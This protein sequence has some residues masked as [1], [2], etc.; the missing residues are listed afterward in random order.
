MTHNVILRSTINAA[1]NWLSYSPNACPFKHIHPST[2]IAIG[3]VGSSRR[4]TSPPS[5][6]LVATLANPCA[7]SAASTHKLRTK[8]EAAVCAAIEAYG[9]T[10]YNESAP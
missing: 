2:N 6:S 3:I 7:E 9:L 1:P 4:E 10:A 8:N 5:V